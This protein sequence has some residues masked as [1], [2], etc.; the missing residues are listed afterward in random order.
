MPSGR[1]ILGTGTARL[2]G[3]SA[4]FSELATKAEY[5]KTPNAVRLPATA[6]ARIIPTRPVA[7][8]PDAEGH[9]VVERRHP[10]HQREVD[11]LSPRVEQPGGRQ[12]DRV[13]RPHPADREI[14]RNTGRQE[15]EQEC[16]RCEKDRAG[17]DA[18]SALAGET[19]QPALATPRVR[20]A[21]AGYDGPPA[22]HIG[23]IR[24]EGLERPRKRA[25]P[26]QRPTAVA[27]AAAGARR[28]GRSAGCG[29]GRCAAP[30]CEVRRNS[31]SA[32]AARAGAP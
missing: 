25:F 17:S 9:G 8:S 31:G 5:L 22:R 24:T 14:G 19:Y 32:T 11:R 6:A 15:H 12:E 28:P 3:A 29:A 23:P 1:A 7:R 27:A 10:Q 2:R 30:D 20:P 18:R 13:A 4:R 16:R 21:A 26:P